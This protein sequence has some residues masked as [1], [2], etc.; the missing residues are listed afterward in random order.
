MKDIPSF[1]LLNL[2]GIDSES[3]SIIMHGTALNDSMMYIN[4]LC[5]CHLCNLSF[6]LCHTFSSN[7]NS[8][9]LV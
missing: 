5:S 3:C 6:L 9:S 7:S 1:C 4:V 8:A 2:N